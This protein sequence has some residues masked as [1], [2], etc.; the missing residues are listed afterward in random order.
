MR[1][2][3]EGSGTGD[4]ASAIDGAGTPSALN[5]W[6]AGLFESKSMTRNG[7]SG[8]AEPV[9]IGVKVLSRI[10]KTNSSGVPASTFVVNERLK[11]SVFPGVKV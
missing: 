6:I 10:E 9:G 1:A 4:G 2:A 11:L 3:E 5:V 7:L 8:E